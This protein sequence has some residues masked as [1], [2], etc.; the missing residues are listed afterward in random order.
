MITFR[1]GIQFHIFRLE[2]AL[3]IHH[4]SIWSELAG[5][6]VDVNSGADRAHGPNSLHAWDLAIDLDTA[7]DKIEDLRQLHG[8]LSRNLPPQYDVVLERDHVHV[9]WDAR[10]G[11]APLTP[12]YQDP[13]APATPGS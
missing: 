1:A 2:I 8:Y 3:A 4:A 12:T 10:R 13:L 9:E 11:P 6:G 5:V 7:R